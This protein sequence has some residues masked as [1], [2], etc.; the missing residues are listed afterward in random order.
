MSDPRY[1]G[2]VMPTAKP[3]TRAAARTTTPKPATK[4]KPKKRPKKRADPAK[5]W[6]SYLR[7]YRPGLQQYV[8]EG[9]T[10]QYG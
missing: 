8:L 3:A 10:R 5:A 9:L 1:D 6:A 2:P 7:W 4:A